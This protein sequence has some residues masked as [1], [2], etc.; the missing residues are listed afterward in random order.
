MLHNYTQMI[1]IKRYRWK[2][3]TCTCVTAAK[4]AD[5]LSE[6]QIF[7]VRSLALLFFLTPKVIKYM[8][9][10]SRVVATSTKPTAIEVFFMVTA[11]I[12]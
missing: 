10:A 9:S 4:H 8:P 1:C 7:Q 11:Y 3:Q 12:L 5:A 2:R 6:T